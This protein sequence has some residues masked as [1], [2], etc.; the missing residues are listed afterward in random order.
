MT[1]ADREARMLDAIYRVYGLQALWTPAAGGPVT[2]P[3]VRYQTQDDVA[4]LGQS[5]ILMRSEVLFWR[6]S[7]EQRPTDPGQGD[8]VEVTR[9]SGALSSYRVLSDPRL[10]PEG[11]EWRCVVQLLTV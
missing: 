7:D 3:V 5:E 1:M 9:P 8:L 6:A 11:L 2:T 4:G 10:E